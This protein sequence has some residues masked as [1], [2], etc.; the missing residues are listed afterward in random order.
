MSLFSQTIQTQLSGEIVRAAGLAFFDFKDAPMGLWEGDGLLITNDG[1]SWQGL[2]QYAGV[3]GINAPMGTEAAQVSFKLS[4][5]SPEIVT[6]VQNSSSMVKGRDVTIFI[7]FFDDNNCPLD[8]PY[9]I[10]AG[11]M[12]VMRYSAIGADKRDVTLTAEGLFTNRN[13][14]PYSFYTDKDQQARFQYDR[15]LEYVSTLINKT[16]TW[17]DY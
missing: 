14:P 15:G 4:G 8:N 16:V 5:V 17:P 10:W 11:V 9:A 12:D 6:A 3:S 1:R 7:Q 13:H 2:G